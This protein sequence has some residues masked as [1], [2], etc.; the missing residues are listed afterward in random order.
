MAVK[1]FAANLSQ[2]LLK[3]ISLGEEDEIKA[4]QVKDFSDISADLMDIF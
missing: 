3:K 4:T 1:N 2:R